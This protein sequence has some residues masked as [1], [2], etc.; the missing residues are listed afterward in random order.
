MEE[1][2]KRR[3]L[4]ALKRGVHRIGGD[5]SIP[6]TTHVVG[7]GR[8]GANAIC[9][10]IRDLEPDAPKFT[11]LAIDI[12]DQDL[13]E[14]RALAAKTPAERAEVTT[15]AL[16]VPDP[17]DL[18]DA[19]SRYGTFLRLEY[20]N[21]RWMETGQP[22]LPRATQIPAGAG[23]HFERA[24]AKA[25][26]GYAYYAGPRTLEGALRTF[27]TTID[28]ER[29]Q[30]VVA[31]VFGMGGGTGSGIAVDLA[32]HLSNG[33]FGR[34]ALVAGIGIAPC[35]GD[36]PAHTG[37]RLFNVISEL[38]ILGDEHKNRGVV[39]SCGEMFRNPFTAGF[40]MIP[41]QHIWQAT[42]D[43][44]ATNIRVDK[45]IAALLTARRGTQSLGITAAAQLGCRAVNAAL[46]CQNAL[47]T[48]VDS[49]AGFH[50]CG[51]P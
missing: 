51:R 48:T 37:A 42:Q 40:I 45:E 14:L 18:F 19:L 41:Q 9:Q 6:L 21:H 24:V 35:E 47:G 16:T 44:A 39:M 5:Q 43:L 22:W 49:H 13:G 8:A 50:R 46:G 7:I 10:I 34:R 33:L 31:I 23:Q 17:E 4:D 27:A 26:Y 12:G 38:D 28:T 1:R 25:I 20:P 32:R 2:L 11:A 15:V 3:K 30:A 29:S 36:Q